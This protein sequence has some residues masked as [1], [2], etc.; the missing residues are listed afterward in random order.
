MPKGRLVPSPNHRSHRSAWARKS[1]LQ[2][3]PVAAT[4]R[5]PHGGLTLRLRLRYGMG[6][7]HRHFSRSPA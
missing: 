7:A 6:T 4:R 5:K 3:E 1:Q 2:T